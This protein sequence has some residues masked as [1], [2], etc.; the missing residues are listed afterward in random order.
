MI[1]TE[2]TTLSNGWSSRATSRR[3]GFETQKARIEPWRSAGPR[4]FA[5]DRRWN[6]PSPRA[7]ALTRSDGVERSAAASRAVRSDAFRCGPSTD[8]SSIALPLHS[9]IGPSPAADSSAG[10]RQ[11]TPASHGSLAQHPRGPAAAWSRALSCLQASSRP[12]SALRMVCP[13]R[14]RS[15]RIHVRPQADR[16]R[17]PAPFVA[18][19]GNA[20]SVPFASPCFESQTCRLQLRRFF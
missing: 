9:S 2:H 8:P 6:R 20:R 19:A 4:L 11:C 15:Q 17:V 10:E 13:F 3:G 12:V 1:V 7:A 5:A 16:G 18:E 14:R